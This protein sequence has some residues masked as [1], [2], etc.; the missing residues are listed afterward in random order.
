MMGLSEM[1]TSRKA[2]AKSET[3]KNCIY[4]WYSISTLRPSPPSIMSAQFLYMYFLCRP[5]SRF[6]NKHVPESICKVYKHC[7]VYVHFPSNWTR[8]SFGASIS[9]ARVDP[10]LTH[11]AVAQCIRYQVETG[12]SLLFRTVRR[13]VPPA[14]SHPMPIPSSH[15]SIHPSPPV[16]LVYTIQYV[17]ARRLHPMG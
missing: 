15:P 11:L 8:R 9:I 2:S 13:Q 12:T 14:I 4:V 16:H 7:T 1:L 5:K 17:T 10:Q 3:A 6:I